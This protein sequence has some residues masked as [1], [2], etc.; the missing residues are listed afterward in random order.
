M[1][2]QYAVRLTHD[3]GWVNVITAATDAASA[4]EL[5]L[6]AEQAPRRSVQW[7]AE[8]PICGY[9]DQPAT[10]KTREGGEFLC[11]ACARSQTDGPLVDYVTDLLVTQWPRVE[12]NNAP[13]RD[14]FVARHNFGSGTPGSYRVSD[15][16]RDEVILVAVNRD[17]ARFSVAWLRENY[18]TGTDKPVPA[19]RELGTLVLEAWQGYCRENPGAP[20][21]FF[22]V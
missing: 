15:L 16:A 14:R 9:C 7:V 4:V 6:K 3:A 20:G 17:Q 5:V 19:S 18:P 10:R 8:Q 13:L 12:W 22:R 2:R 21:V 1:I 11:R